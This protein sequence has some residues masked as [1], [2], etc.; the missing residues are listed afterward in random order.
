MREQSRVLYI[1]LLLVLYSLRH[2][3]LRTHFIYSFN[4]EQVASFSQPL[5]I[6]ISSADGLGQNVYTYDHPRETV[7]LYRAAEA[8][9]N[10][11][12]HRFVRQFYSP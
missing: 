4:L 9:E 11:I 10:R 2:S 3:A 1:I 6:L 12:Q 5:A 8:R 7:Q